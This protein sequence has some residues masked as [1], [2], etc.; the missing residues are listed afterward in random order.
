M[1]TDSGQWVATP[2]AD[3]VDPAE[4]A[5]AHGAPAAVVVAAAAASEAIADD[6][7]ETAQPSSVA[8]PKS[9]EPVQARF[10][11]PP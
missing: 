2:D 10:V 4:A 9:P 6:S 8:E 5:A 11:P 7:P 1:R 3:E